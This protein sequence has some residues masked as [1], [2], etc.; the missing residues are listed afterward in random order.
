MRLPHCII[1]LSHCHQGLTSANCIIASQLRTIIYAAHR[2]VHLLLFQATSSYQTAQS[3]NPQVNY[4]P[5][6]TPR[7]DVCICYY[8]RSSNCSVPSD[9]KPRDHVIP[10][11]S[12]D[13]LLVQA[14]ISSSKSTP[15]PQLISYISPRFNF[16]IPSVKSRSP[17]SNRPTCRPRTI[18]YVTYRRTPAP[19]HQAIIHPASIAIIFDEPIG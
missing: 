7:I 5:S 2:R 13:R 11:S 4:V 15:F 14:P 1:I 12:Q 16:V 19:S 18:A 6:S 10:Y 8:S 3:A 17:H 9:Y